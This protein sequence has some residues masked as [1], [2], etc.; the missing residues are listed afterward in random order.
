MSVRNRASQASSSSRDGIDSWSLQ[1]PQLPGFASRRT[2]SLRAKQ[3]SG[4]GA[5]VLA[6]TAGTARKE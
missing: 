3:Y 4:A 5:A 6:G 2:G 1:T